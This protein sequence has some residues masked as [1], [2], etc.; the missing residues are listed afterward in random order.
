MRRDTCDAEAGLGV[1]WD[2]ATPAI[3]TIIPCRGNPEALRRAVRSAIS[4]CE[5]NEVIVID[6]ASEQPDAEQIAAIAR[7]HGARLIRLP[8]RVGPA[9]ARNAG[10]D[11]SETPYIAFLDA[12][13]FWLPGKLA[14]QRAAMDAGR[15]SFTFMRYANFHG[16][17][18][19]PMPAPARLSRRALLGNTAI[20]CSTVM[21]SRAFVA[22]RRFPDAPAEDF[23]FWVA[24]LGEAEEAHLVGDAVMVLRSKGGRSSNRVAA[25]WRCWRTMRDTLGLP[26]LPALGHFTR[27]A[28]RAA[29]K[30]WLPRPVQPLEAELRGVEP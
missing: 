11:A 14:A 15:L 24:L 3:A 5:P 16:A 2:A 27:Y 26:L 20:G 1:S 25:A 30:H 17:E 28:L 9:M 7:D 12:D 18:A 6:D 22:G 23:A 4:Q 13:D 19:R 10:I 8:E 21:L 29:G